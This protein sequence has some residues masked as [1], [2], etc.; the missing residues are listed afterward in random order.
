MIH[1]FFL[2]SIYQPLG[3][4]GP[5]YLPGKSTWYFNWDYFYTFLHCDNVLFANPV[6]NCYRIKMNRFPDTHFFQSTCGETEKVRY[7]LSS[8]DRFE[9]WLRLLFNK[10]LCF[11]VIQLIDML[12][13][14][15]TDLQVRC[16]TLVQKSKG[17]TNFGTPDQRFLLHSQLF[18]KFR[19]NVLCQQ[20]SPVQNL[21][22]AALQRKFKCKLM[23][24]FY[25]NKLVLW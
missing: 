13:I 10:I 3:S 22:W 2:N 14:H 1:V 23:E 11:V 15:A 18:I 9:I 8:F 24:R 25:H 19:Q 17:T 7:T 4:R 21:N 16:S 5:V 12:N 6:N 20:V